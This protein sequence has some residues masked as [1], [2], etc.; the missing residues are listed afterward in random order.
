MLEFACLTASVHTC[1]CVCVC[2]FTISFCSNAPLSVGSQ[3]FT[4]PHLLPGSVGDS[5]AKPAVS[6]L[7]DDIDEQELPALQDRGDDEG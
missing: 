3:S 5:V 6:N 7:V 2:E 4:Q 1:V